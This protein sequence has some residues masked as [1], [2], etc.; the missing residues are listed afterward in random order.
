MS[1]EWWN[2]IV[3]SDNF[4]EFV[5]N[6]R[7]GKKTFKWLCEKLRPAL[8][9]DPF[10]IREPLTVEIKVAISL[11]KLA[12]CSEYRVVGNQFGVHKTSVYRN[13]KQFCKAVIDILLCMK[14]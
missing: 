1:K 6:F 10:C 4:D 5:E 8:K 7:I 11:Y 2:N 14:K 13:L 12:S 9:P 3:N